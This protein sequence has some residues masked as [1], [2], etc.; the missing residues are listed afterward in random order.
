MLTN[1]ARWRWPWLHLFHKP[2][3]EHFGL[4]A[5]FTIIKAIYIN[6]ISKNS[7]VCTVLQ[8][9]F[10]QLPKTTCSHQLTLSTYISDVITCCLQLPQALTIPKWPKTK[11]LNC[12]VEDSCES[13]LVKPFVL[14]MMLSKEK[15]TSSSEN[16]LLKISLTI[17]FVCHGNSTP[18]G[19]KKDHTAFHLK[20]CIPI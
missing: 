7:I 12:R 9:F 8:V 15:Y 13:D 16:F 19:D 6:Q 1:N 14:P 3:Q 5:C 20:T 4:S 10:V 2:W 11:F 17:L 18:K